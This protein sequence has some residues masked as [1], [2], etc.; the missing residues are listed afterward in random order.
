MGCG[1]STL[2]PE[3]AAHNQ[4]ENGVCRVPQPMDKRKDFE[5]GDD[6]ESLHG[7]RNN[8]KDVVMV[9]KPMGDEEAKALSN[10]E[11]LIEKSTVGRNDIKVEVRSSGD[12]NYCAK[13]NAEDELEYR[14]DDFIVGPRSPSFR[15]YCNNYDR[16]DRSSMEFSNGSDSTESIKNDSELLLVIHAVL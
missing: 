10:G 9:M 15:E 14:D 8:N 6:G 2:D 16:G 7:N 5:N 11:R 1:M 3:D 12:N 13:K 4:C